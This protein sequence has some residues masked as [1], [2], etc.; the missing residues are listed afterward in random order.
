MTQRTT[1]QAHRRVCPLD[2]TTVIGQFRRSIGCSRTHR[3]LLNTNLPALISASMFRCGT[4]FDAPT[5]L[6]FRFGT[7]FDAPT[8]L[9]FRCGTLFEA[10]AWDC[11]PNLGYH[12]VAWDCT[13]SQVVLVAWDCIL[14]QV[15]LVAWD[16]TLS[17]PVEVAWDCIL[18]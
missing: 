14:S 1:A 16:C 9:I 15:G 18:G 17:Q 5:D 11:T 10:V 8:D 6:L 2:G 4:L 3:R 12:L 13:L 7:L